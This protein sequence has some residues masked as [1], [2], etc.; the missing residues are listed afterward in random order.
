MSGQT[1]PTAGKQERRERIAPI[2][3]RIENFN[4]P[5]DLKVYA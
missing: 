2:H 5:G 3:E 1:S 4:T